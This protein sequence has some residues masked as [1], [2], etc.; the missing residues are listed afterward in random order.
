MVKKKYTHMDTRIHVQ[1]HMT[2]S[3]SGRGAVLLSLADST[4]SFPHGCSVS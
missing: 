1:I 4:N 2:V 3:A